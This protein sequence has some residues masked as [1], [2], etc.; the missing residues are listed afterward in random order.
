M[1]AES[2][3]SIGTALKSQV[4]NI[5]SHK[6]AYG[7]ISFQVRAMKNGFSILKKNLKRKTGKDKQTMWQ[8]HRRSWRWTRCGVL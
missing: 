8:C 3:R 7:R 2:F 5:N 1:L 6:H 4:L